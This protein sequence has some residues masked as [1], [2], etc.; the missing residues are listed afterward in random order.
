MACIQG[1]PPSGPAP[2]APERE[3]RRLL[4]TVLAA[5]RVVSM[6]DVATYTDTRRRARHAAYLSVDPDWS[7]TNRLDEGLLLAA[8]ATCYRRRPKP[9]S[10][11]VRQP[12]RRAG[13]PSR[14]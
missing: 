14:S 5:I 2:S 9:W 1:M 6:Q 10:R 3:H 4:S 13:R 7:P 12:W 8:V 11:S